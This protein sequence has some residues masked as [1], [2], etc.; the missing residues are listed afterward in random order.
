MNQSDKVFNR[1]LFNRL[2]KA[3]ESRV[4]RSESRNLGSEVEDIMKNKKTP[5]KTKKKTASKKTTKN[6]TKAL[7]ACAN[8]W[9]L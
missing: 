2:V 7:V 8:H 6:T 4:S 5:T 9:A 1:Y 3:A